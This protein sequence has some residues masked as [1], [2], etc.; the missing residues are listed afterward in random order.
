MGLDDVTM[1]GCMCVCVFFVNK[2]AAT[3]TESIQYMTR[4]KQT[5]TFLCIM[6][7]SHIRG[8]LISRDMNINGR[9]KKIVRV[10]YAA[11]NDFSG[12]RQKPVAA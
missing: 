1:S 9:L 2:C 7:V 6:C 8:N 11:R 3:F 12:S 10:V 4:A 5:N